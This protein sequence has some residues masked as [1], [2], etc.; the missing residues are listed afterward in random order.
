[1]YPALKHVHG[2]LCYSQSFLFNYTPLNS[3]LCIHYVCNL[4]FVSQI[5]DVCMTG[6]YA[7]PEGHQHAV[8]GWTDGG[9]SC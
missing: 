2:M 9:C 7:V 1:M 6:V 3:I 8:S 4:N 5:S